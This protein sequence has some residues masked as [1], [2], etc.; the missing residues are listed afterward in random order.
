MSAGAMG[1]NGTGKNATRSPT[2][3]SLR[4]RGPR[5]KGG[6]VSTTGY[7]GNSELLTVFVVV[8]LGVSGLITPVQPSRYPNWLSCLNLVPTM[9]RYPLE[10][11]FI[12]SASF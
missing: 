12:T 1:Q 7:F 9:L 4:E 2:I 5:R 3:R 6:R 10:C 11:I 8:S